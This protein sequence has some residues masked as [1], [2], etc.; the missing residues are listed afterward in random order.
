MRHTTYEAFAC[1][2]NRERYQNLAEVE[3]RLSYDAEAVSALCEACR[4]SAT[5][6]GA[7]NLLLL[8]LSRSLTKWSQS[9]EVGALLGWVV[10]ALTRREDPLSFVRCAVKDARKSR[11][12]QKAREE[13]HA[14]AI[15]DSGALSIGR[16]GEG[17]VWASEAPAFDPILRRK[18]QTGLARLTK[19]QREAILLAS[20]GY[21][22]A[23]IAAQL[24]VAP[25]TIRNLL[26]E[27]RKNLRDILAKVSP[28]GR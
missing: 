14:Q 8:A 3:A 17:F 11:K 5:A 25:K 21:S 7:Y 2:P 20:E 12:A 10:E 13:K 22:A 26:V 16:E 1:L 23:E 18:L 28:F 6:K 19:S 9:E 4:R 24:G 15:S 27:A